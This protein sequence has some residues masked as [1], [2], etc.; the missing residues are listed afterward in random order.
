M[1]K[2]LMKASQIFG[3]IPGQ[4][5]FQRDSRRANNETFGRLEFFFKN[6]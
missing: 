6:S 1:G 4:E 2:H 3:N 5:I